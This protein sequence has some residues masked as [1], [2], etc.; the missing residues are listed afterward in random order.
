MDHTGELLLTIAT[1]FSANNTVHT[2]LDRL[3]LSFVSNLMH[4]HF[5]VIEARNNLPGRFPSTILLG[6]VL[7]FLPY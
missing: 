3:C 1:A 6:V 4:S 7:V 2:L 5:S